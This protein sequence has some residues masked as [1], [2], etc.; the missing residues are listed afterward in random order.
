MGFFDKKMKEAED[1]AEKLI[2]DYIVLLDKSSEASSVK[3]MAQKGAPV[4][5]IGDR[6]ADTHKAL[7]AELLRDADKTSLLR[8]KTRQQIVEQFCVA[9]WRKWIGDDP[10]REMTKSLK[11][12]QP[13][14]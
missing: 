13:R 7:F 6:A 4:S 5:S 1:D 14:T 2:K 9:L 3:Q 8:S 12:I 10:Y 11:M